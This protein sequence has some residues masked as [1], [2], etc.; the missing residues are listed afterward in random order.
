MLHDYFVVYAA[1]YAFSLFMGLLVCLKVGHIFGRR[2][3]ALEDNGDDSG[4]GALDT[5]VFGLLGLLLAF[6][7]SGAIARYDI[8][9]DLLTEEASAASGA[10]ARLDILPTISQPPLRTLMRQYVQARIDAYQAVIDSSAAEAAL[11]RSVRL[12]EQLWKQGIDA[13]KAAGNAAILSQVSDSLDRLFEAPTRQ[14]AAQRNHPPVV[15]YVLLFVLA[16]MSALLAGRRMSRQA[17]LPRMHA[18]VFAVAVALTMYVIL[19][20]EYPRS[21]FFNPDPTNRML[22]ETLH[23]MQ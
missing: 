7:F 23:G 5:A 12:Q 13:A 8:H 17:A 10:Y 11:A 4:A 22:V 14:T 1:I 20:L 18:V 15:I 21:G 6:S 16:M 3:R 9:R 2:T 19:D